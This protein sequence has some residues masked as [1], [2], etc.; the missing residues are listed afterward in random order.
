[1][2]EIISSTP[3]FMINIYR[4]LNDK[5]DFNFKRNQTVHSLITKCN[6]LET[7]N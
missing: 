4:F 7:I 1:M 3:D 6:Y 5:I 2:K